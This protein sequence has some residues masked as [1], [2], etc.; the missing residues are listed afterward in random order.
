MTTKMIAP[1]NQ[2]KYWG[3]NLETVGLFDLSVTPE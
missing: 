2:P 3:G 1:Q